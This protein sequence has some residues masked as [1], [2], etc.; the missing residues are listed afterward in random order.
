MHNIGIV[1]NELLD[2]SQP[3]EYSCGGGT[4][5][6]PHPAHP[7]VF[8]THNMYWDK[9]YW[10]SLEQMIILRTIS[11][12]KIISG[13]GYSYVVRIEGKSMAPEYG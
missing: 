6:V 8:L 1:R 13:C 10:V 5:P 7:G 11:L 9:I 3:D 12:S 2:E 4:R